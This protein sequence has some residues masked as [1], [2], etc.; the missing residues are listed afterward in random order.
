[1]EDSAIIEAVRFCFSRLKL[2]VEPSGAVRLAAALLTG[3][4]QA[5]APDRAGGSGRA[6]GA[7]GSG[8]RVR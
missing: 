2:V 4:V 1:M 7:P 5:G 8:G 3:A 6:A